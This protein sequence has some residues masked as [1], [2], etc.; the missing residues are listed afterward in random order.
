MKEG[1]QME[2]LEDRREQADREER[3][4]TGHS[5]R[6]NTTKKWTRQTWLQ[7][8]TSSEELMLMSMVAV[9]QLP[10][11]AARDGSDLIMIYKFYI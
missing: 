5:E 3:N 6:K 2:E 11:K 7:T 1:L 10:R 4:S 8:Q 9:S